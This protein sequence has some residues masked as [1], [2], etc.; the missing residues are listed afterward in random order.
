M[1]MSG[2]PSLTVGNL[3]LDTII[4]MGGFDNSWQQLQSRIRQ[5]E[6]TA[7]L[8]I[9]IDTSALD[10]GITKATQQIQNLQRIAS[11][12]IVL[13]VNAAQ[14]TAAT[15]AVA[16]HT[17]AQNNAQAAITKTTQAATQHTTATN[18]LAQANQASAASFNSVTSSGNNYFGA[19]GRWV[20]RGAAFRLGQIA[21]T[22][23]IRATKAAIDDIIGSAVSYE[24]SLQRLQ[25]NTTLTAADTDLISASVKRLS[26]E[27]GAPLEGLINGYR[28]ASSEG[29]TLSQQNEVVDAGMKS[30]M[31]TGA[32]LAS[33]VNIAAVGMHIFAGE[34]LTATQMM[35]VF[36][37]A[38]AD[39]RVEMAEW[40]TGTQRA[41]ATGNTFGQTVNEISAALTAMTRQG[42][43][44]AQ[45][46][47]LYIQLAQHI[48]EPGVAAEKTLQQIT[49]LTGVDLVSDF[50]KQ[51]LAAKGMASVL[52]DV[53][54]AAGILHDDGFISKIIPGNRGAQAAFILTGAG[55]K[56]YKDEMTRLD[57]IISGKS[58]PTQDAY[59][60]MLGTT[61]GQ[62]G[63]LKREFDLFKLQI[64]TELL[65][66][67]K[68]LVTWMQTLLKAMGVD[69]KIPGLD[70]AK[71]AQAAST[72]EAKKQKD[73]LDAA[74]Q[75]S[76]AHTESM[77]AD[78]SS[79]IADANSQL[80]TMKTNLDDNTKS[81]N[82]LNVEAAGYKVQL[83]GI[84]QQELLPKEQL[85]N[86]TKAG[87]TLKGYKDQNTADQKAI[88]GKYDPQITSDKDLL[89]TINHLNPDD[90][91][92]HMDILSNNEAVLR[93][94]LAKP[95]TSAFDATIAEDKK[96]LDDLGTANT[97]AVDA[98]IKDLQDQMQALGRGA[99]DA[100]DQ[101][102]LDLK[103]KI[104]NLG[105]ANTTAVD[106]R[107]EYLKD[108]MRE[109]GK[110]A[111][112]A[113][114]Q[115]LLGLKGQVNEIDRAISETQAKLRAPD[116]STQGQTNALV[117]LQAQLAGGSISQSAFDAQYGN[118]S[119]QKAAINQHNITAK[120]ALQHDS[121]QD[122]KT[123][124]TVA[125]NL[126][127]HS[128][129][130][131]LKKAELAK[132]NALVQYNADMLKLTNAGDLLKLNDDIAASLREQVAFPI[133]QRIDE[134]TAARDKELEPLKAQSLLLD[135][136]IAK[137][138]EK[139]AAINETLTSLHNEG[140][141]IQANLDKVNEQKRSIDAQNASYREQEKQIKAT[142]AALNGPG[143]AGGG[144]DTAITPDNN[145][146]GPALNKATAPDRNDR[147][148][149]ATNKAAV[150]NALTDA[151]DAT[152]GKIKEL[153]T[154]TSG[155]GLQRILDDLAK[156]FNGLKIEAKLD[157]KAFFE[158]VDFVKALAQLLSDFEQHHFDKFPADFSALGS[159]MGG[160]GGGGA[161]TGGTGA[162][163][164][165]VMGP[166]AGDAT[167]GGDV[168]RTN[169]L[170]F[171]VSGEGN[172][173]SYTMDDAVADKVRA[174]N[175]GITN[176]LKDHG[177]GGLTNFGDAAKGAPQ[178]LGSG[179]SASD[180][181]GQIGEI[182]QFTQHIQDQL[183]DSGGAQ[184]AIQSFKDQI[185]RE[186]GQGS[187]AA[188]AV[189][190]AEKT[191]MDTF[192]AGNAVPTSFADTGA[193]AQTT[194]ATGGTVDTAFAQNDN[195]VADTTR[196][197]DTAAGSWGDAYGTAGTAATTNLGTGG[198][199]DTAHTQWGNSLDTAARNGRGA[200][201]GID[202][203]VT[204]TA[205]NATQQFGP[206]G[207]ADQAHK[208][209]TTSIQT[210]QANGTT[211]LGTLDSSVTGTASNATKQF[212]PNGTTDAA[213]TNLVNKFNATQGDVDGTIGILDGS[214]TSSADNTYKKFGPGGS[215]DTSL[216]NFGTSTGT[217]SSTAVGHFGD[218]DTAVITTG[219][220]AGTIITN[221]TTA[222][223]WLGSTWQGVSANISKPFTD[224]WP[225]IDTFFKSL[226]T[227][228]E[229]LATNF[230]LPFDKYQGALTG[231]I[232][233]VA[234]AGGA[235]PATGNAPA[236]HAAGLNFPGSPNGPMPGH[237]A[238]IGERGPEMMYVPPNASI[239]PN[240]MLGAHADGLNMDALLGGMGGTL[241]HHANALVDGMMTALGTPAV[242]GVEGA[243]AAMGKMIGDGA[244]KWLSTS[245]VENP[246]SAV[247]QGGGG[248]V[249]VGGRGYMLP[250]QGTIT[251]EFGQTGFYLE[252][253]GFHDGV[254]IANDIGTP[255]VADAAGQVD[256]A[257]WNN[258]G[259]GN[260]VHI[261]HDGGI[262]TWMGH[263]SQVL[264]DVGAV[265]QKGQ[266][267]GL[268][269]S[270][271]AS[272]GS[273]VH[274]GAHQD[275]QKI[276]PM[277]LLGNLPAVTAGGG[278]P[279]GDLSSVQQY[280]ANPAVVGWLQDALSL[281][282][283][284]PDWLPALII[285]ADG[286]SSDT[287][288]AQNNWDS[289]AA[290]GHPS[291][292][293]MQVIDSTFAANMANGHGDIWNPVDNAA[294]AIN[295]IRDRYGSPWNLAGVNAVQQSGDIHSWIGYADGG[296]VDK[297]TLGMIGEGR[298]PEIVSPVPMLKEIVRENSGGTT[299]NMAPG[300]VVINVGPRD[301]PYTAG[302][303]AA[304]GFRDALVAHGR[305]G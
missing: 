143:G 96:K 95:D 72:D 287:P 162:I 90:I 206:S 219:G 84:H 3:R 119:R 145:P 237:M 164:N 134:N 277:S 250:A 267:I 224:A 157:L 12:P 18:Q 274:W 44:A 180:L 117:G 305:T 129:E 197:L 238:L 226:S 291:R 288:D 10:G 45:S 269:G 216:T 303:Q 150:H 185:T 78:K 203:S 52:G 101:Q 199:T 125:F 128:L 227:G 211:A 118:L 229:W 210:A 163:A 160:G 68:E 57:D 301:D 139:K 2:A 14:V 102:I 290:A 201:S 228:L 21:M 260:W 48:A 4:D 174:V 214:V 53:N 183:G 28:L 19:L 223:N 209:L 190:D 36:H 69:F 35:D 79:A 25:A 304:D 31:A 261:Q 9:G 110:S 187:D 41:Y 218:I 153:E 34:G 222:S 268:M 299:V 40:V 123:R 264:T 298:D 20:E 263:M 292:G 5:L 282:G 112:D 11:A 60:K 86:A 75:A 13:N 138:N 236:A 286:E 115:N 276:D 65:P 74:K 259:F 293:L 17:T 213:T 97:A 302:R 225:A 278:G 63:I 26:A 113:I 85:A 61:A 37:Q 122:E 155:G 136:Q 257:G 193:A 54:K 184:A 116:Q 111:T 51:G 246:V 253:G 300:T 275:G 77:L 146:S 262:E 252:P 105:T 177:L 200:L 186:M 73:A 23:A 182:D 215:T 273:H 181:G 24:Q 109:L 141:G 247:L 42:Y 255:I 152:V 220:P 295:Y 147:Q 39:S 188:T 232:G 104:D 92:R 43:S 55:A 198:V 66:V 196:T 132:T 272:T 283:G 235:T 89:A 49:K 204:G 161:A 142:L 168:V 266:E 175:D 165:P 100:L 81:M 76:D 231:F 1:S 156:I 82:A 120:T 280:I 243:G 212:G 294:A 133:R 239:I 254:D 178:L 56:D 121:A 285:A 279:T 230:K 167:K 233:P 144:G 50:T 47:T 170:G 103:G 245:S 265:L 70:E 242:P 6:S 248:S 88:T 38:A 192:G 71:A 251:Q 194:F 159:A 151:V 202:T 27:S 67:V 289:N 281:A 87:N 135:G 108:Q 131:D 189:Q 137:N 176:W 127:K 124:I 205:T 16:S 241:A 7:K 244:K 169:S 30:A 32:D 173:Q 22:E 171:G 58:T 221:L 158:G 99:T 191:F 207:P 29:L 46:Q 217:A 234:P 98:R 271:G 208:N 106:A 126:A 91:Q 33:T 256:Q 172:N 15:A 166:N 297:P 179:V 8:T 107:I 64:G 195:G 296:Y 59:N 80:D 114:D 140:A 62:V 93:L 284:P 148:F 249:G 154:W 240:H 94:K 130:L 270:T 83:D 149:G 258:Y